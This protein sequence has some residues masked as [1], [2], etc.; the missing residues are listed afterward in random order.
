MVLVV[1]T[2]ITNKYMPILFIWFDYGSISLRLDEFA[3][4]FVGLFLIYVHLTISLGYGLRLC[5]VCLVSNGLIYFLQAFSDIF[6]YN[7]LYD[8]LLY[9]R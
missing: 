4:V 3:C 5:S 8:V 2:G 1:V 9:C 6:L 7:Y